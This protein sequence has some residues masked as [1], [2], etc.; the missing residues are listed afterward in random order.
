AAGEVGAYD[1]TSPGAGGF[2]LFHLGLLFRPVKWWRAGRG[3][4]REIIR[5]EERRGG[6]EGRNRGAADH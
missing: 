6:E 5:S 2:G 4:N 1:D 3:E